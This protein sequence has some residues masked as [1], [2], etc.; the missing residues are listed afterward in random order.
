MR[1]LK[2]GT[3]ICWIFAVLFFVC[4]FTFISQGKIAEFFTGVL[5]A[6]VLGFCGY[7][8]QNKPKSSVVPAQK[9]RQQISVPAPE[10]KREFEHRTFK[11]VGV[12]FDN[13]DGTNRQSLLRKIKFK[14][15][16]FDGDVVFDLFRYE[17]EGKPACGVTADDA[18]VG[19]IATTDV[20]FVVLN[21]DR[22]ICIT[23]F[24]AY[25]GGRDEE[26][27]KKSIGAEIVVRYC[28]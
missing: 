18:Q 26:G 8:I 15:S 23:D 22:M 20:D 14:D 13:E 5:I 21:W 17:Y 9:V 6:A 3:L 2:K 11:I 28:V 1:K 12:T 27:K 25:G 16:P 4:S 19:N 10:V 7:R 24:T